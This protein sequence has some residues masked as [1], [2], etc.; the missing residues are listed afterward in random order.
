MPLGL[1]HLLPLAIWNLKD[2]GAPGVAHLHVPHVLRPGGGRKP[3]REVPHHSV[4]PEGPWGGPYK[5]LSWREALGLAGHALKS[6]V[7]LKECEK[8]LWG[9]R[10]NGGKADK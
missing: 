7:I 3:C 8:C 1:G 2:T 6:Q 4:T 5:S 10:L 9:Q